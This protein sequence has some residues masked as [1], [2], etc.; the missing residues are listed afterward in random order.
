MSFK[1]NICSFPRVCRH[2][3]VH[4][5]APAAAAIDYSSTRRSERAAA[6]IGSGSAT[7]RLSCPSLRRKSSFREADLLNEPGMVPLR[8]T[9]L[10][11]GLMTVVLPSLGLTQSLLPE[12]F[13]TR[14]CWILRQHD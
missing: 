5:A 10:L 9:Q 1:S 8:V 7:L 13:S 6:A 12:T 4:A 2:E 11:L 14:S 3:V